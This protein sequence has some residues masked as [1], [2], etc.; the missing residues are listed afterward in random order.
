MMPHD[1]NRDSLWQNKN[2]MPEVQ[3]KVITLRCFLEMLLAGNA[4]TCTPWSGSTT[5]EQPQWTT[6]PHALFC[7]CGGATIYQVLKLE[8]HGNARLLRHCPHPDGCQ[9]L[10]LLRA[11]KSWKPLPESHW[12]CHALE[13]RAGE[14]MASVSFPAGRCVVGLDKVHKNRVIFRNIKMSLGFIASL[15][16]EAC[17]PM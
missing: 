8:P 4:G 15:E 9:V 14:M 12:P 2:K 7:V 13:S 16:H 1:Q 11:A 6:H 3:G 17:V 5:A 10:L